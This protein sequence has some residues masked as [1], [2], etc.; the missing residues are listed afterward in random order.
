M[1]SVVVGRATHR[2]L[3]SRLIVLDV[4]FPVVREKLTTLRQ[5][6]DLSQGPAPNPTVAKA[7][8]AR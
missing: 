2:V 3:D 5:I 6:V 8:S 1:K 4:T 7:R